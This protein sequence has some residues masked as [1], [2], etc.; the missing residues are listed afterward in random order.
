MAHYK[1]LRGKGNLPETCP[2]CK[3]DDP[4]WQWENDIEVNSGFNVTCSE[5][6]HEFFEQW[7]AVSWQIVDSD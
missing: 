3:T 7:K 1:L 6:N 5:C 2:S 4:D